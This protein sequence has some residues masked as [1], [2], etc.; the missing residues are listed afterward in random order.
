[1]N[2]LLEQFKYLHPKNPGTWPALPKLLALAGPTTAVTVLR[3]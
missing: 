3:F 2:K 1:M